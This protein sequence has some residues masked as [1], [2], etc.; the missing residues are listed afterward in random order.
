MDTSGLHR[1]DQRMVQSPSEGPSSTG[2]GDVIPE[3]PRVSKLTSSSL[4]ETAKPQ[5]KACGSLQTTVIAF[6][7]HPQQRNNSILFLVGYPRGLKI[8]ANIGKRIEAPLPPLRPRPGC[9]FNSVPFPNACN[10]RFPMMKSCA[11]TKIL[12]S[13]EQIILLRG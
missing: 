1:L 10:C 11:T 12:S 6:L 9:E 7:R 2:Q 13:Q 3:T 5:D 8:R 4:W